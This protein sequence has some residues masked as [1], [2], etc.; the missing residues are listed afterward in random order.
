MAGYLIVT[1]AVITLVPFTFRLPSAWRLTGFVTVADLVQNVAL[2]VPLG[3]AVAFAGGR[4]LLIGAVTSLA[5]EIA[6]QFIPGRF[7]SAVDFATN[8]TGAALGAAG[9]QILSVHLGRRSQGAG[10][11]ALDLPLM[12]TVYLVVPLIWLVG[13]SQPMDRGR[14]WLVA[15][16]LLAG[17]IVLGSV[18]R[19]HLEPRGVPRW[20]GACGAGIWAAVALLPGWHGRPAWLAMAATG[21]AIAT[22]L[23]AWLVAAGEPIGRRFEGVTVRRAVAPLVVFVA[24]AAGWPLTGFGDAW[25]WTLGWSAAHEATSRHGILQVLELMAGCAVIGY[26]VAEARSRAVEPLE[27]SR[28]ILALAAGFGGLGVELI[29]SAHSARGASVLEG[30]LVALA[31]MFGGAL[32]W[33]QRRFVLALLGRVPA[34]PSGRV[35]P[36]RYGRIFSPPEADGAPK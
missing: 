28:W 18:S 3:F 5:V 25:V 19:H 14:L 15:L 6:Q 10:I 11:K 4:A 12:G 29:R 16:P 8:A 1:I 24:L 7:P 23:F 35:E 33:R 26:G 27:R 9:Y 31:T 22:G 34:G 2:F 30:I 21:V 13:L 36:V 20:V 17:A 32:Y